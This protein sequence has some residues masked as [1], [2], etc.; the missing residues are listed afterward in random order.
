M[1]LVFEFA[2]CG[3]RLNGKSRR[4]GAKSRRRRRSRRNST[5]ESSA[6]KPRRPSRRRHRRR[7]SSEK[8]TSRSSG[9]K[10]WCLGARRRQRP[11][12]G[13]FPNLRP[14]HSHARPLRRRDAADDRHPADVN[15][16]CL[17]LL[18]AAL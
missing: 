18:C 3:V 7:R 14:R 2:F 9:A 17:L 15:P 5:S 10:S 16:G 12:D 4:S 1:G 11:K 13:A 8:V 6:E